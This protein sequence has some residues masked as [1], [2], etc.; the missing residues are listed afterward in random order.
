MTQPE[1]IREPARELPVLGTFDVVVCG[2]GPAG[3]AA[4]VAAARTGASTLLVEREGY[5]GGAP[6][7]QL[8][9]PILSTNGR[10]FQGVWHDWARE[11]QRIGGISD[12]SREP[13]HAWEWIVGSVD[14]ELVK[15]AWDALVSQAGA[16]I[17]HHAH[18]VA[19]IVEDGVL[20]AAVLETRA[21]RRAVLA[22]CFIDATGDAC[23]AAGAGAGFDCG[24]AGKP[25]A[26]GVGKVWRT[27]NVP[28]PPGA[29]PG[30]CDAGFGRTFGRRMTERFSML[31]LLRVDPLDPWSCSDAEREARR[32]IWDAV[33]WKKTQP[34]LE[35]TYLVD[36]AAHLGFRS[37]RRVHGLAQASDA[38]AWEFTRYPDGIARCSWEIDIHSP[39][40]EGKGI[41]YDDPT[42]QGRAMRAAGGECFDIRYGCLVAKDVDG[43]LVAGRCV[44]ASH[45]AQSSLRIQQTCMALG[46]AAGVA[47]AM[48]VARNVAP[49]AL[50]GVEVAKAVD[51][52][53]ANAEP[54]FEILRDLP[55]AQ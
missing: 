9:S 37:S 33:Q 20:R 30:R 11:L 17:L 13:K 21:G 7:T 43:L 6:V 27:G 23:L 3:A 18:A 4:A 12:L 26:M 41:A 10:D 53:R 22:R 19:G 47:G 2:G 15:Y 39:E 36:T 31:R 50:G 5:L 42:Y 52:A 14:P 8:V 55:R 34:G 25:W 35:D 1:M 45:V 16:K 28:V 46:E 51:S 38:D 54:A 44:S 48:S 40:H 32:R 24:H 49:R 29:V